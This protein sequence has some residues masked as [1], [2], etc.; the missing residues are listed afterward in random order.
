[1]RLYT[2]FRSSTSFRVRIA[3][4][5]KGISY[6]PV[7][8]N[9]KKG[10]QNSEDFRA[11]NG[12]GGVPVL[13]HNGSRITQ[14]LAII[15]Y[16][17][18]LNSTSSFYL[19]D[20]LK[21]IQMKEYAYA[22][23]TDIHAINNL[24]VLNYLSETLNI[25]NEARNTWYRHWID[26]NFAPLEA[27]LSIDLTASQLP[28]GKP[29]LFEIVLVPQVYNALRFEIDMTK[30]PKILAIYETCMKLPAFLNAAPENQADATA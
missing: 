9:L 23:A 16:L 7:F 21:N 11:I 3:L 19:N 14:S 12:I 24:R 13:E 17:D 10:E 4:N 15:E 28:F 27:K 25:D 20:P 26:V 1:M 30:Y 29:T 8:V 6:E 2:Y 18:S 5:L 22:V